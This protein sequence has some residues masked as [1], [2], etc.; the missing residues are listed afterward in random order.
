MILYNLLR[1]LFT[2]V[3]YPLTEC[4]DGHWDV[5]PILIFYQMASFEYYALKLNFLALSRIRNA[6]ITRLLIC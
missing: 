6:F 5:V 1:Q 3:N 4:S 2:T